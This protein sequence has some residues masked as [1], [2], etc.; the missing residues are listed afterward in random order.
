[1]NYIPVNAPSQLL[2]A[3]VS[4]VSASIAPRCARPRRQLQRRDRRGFNVGAACDDGRIGACRSTGRLACDQRTTSAPCA[5]SRRWAAAP[6]PR[7]ATAWTNNCDGR[8]DEGDPG[9]GGAC[10]S[11]MGA[12]LPG[13]FALPG[14]DADLRRRARPERRA[15]RRARQ[16]LHG[17]IDDGV[18][19]AA[20]RQ[21]ARIVLAGPLRLLGHHGLRVHGRDGRHTESCNGVDDDCNGVID[22]NVPGTGVACPTGP[23]GSALCT[24]ASRAASRGCCGARRRAL[25]RAGVHVHARQCATPRSTEAA[26]RCAPAEVRASSAR[27]APRVARASFR[28]PSG[29]SAGRASVCRR[30]VAAACARHRGLPEQRLRGPLRDDHLPARRRFAAAACASRTPAT[31]SGAPP[32]SCAA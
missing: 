13:V 32:V 7:P 30:S 27:A 3:L 16:R 31:R 11:S 25:S 8:V 29:S 28:A 17:M 20:V 5:R 18:P 22:D 19:S 14:R 24:R 12:C 9:G 1:M 21:R 4:L 10:G 15:V 23:D 2:P 6:R 26:P